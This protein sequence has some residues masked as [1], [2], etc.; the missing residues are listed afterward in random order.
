MYQEGV[1]QVTEMNGIESLRLILEREQ[2]RPFAFEEASD[3]AESM[4]SFYEVLAAHAE[5]KTLVPLAS[6]TQ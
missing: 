4:L 5:D 1:E 3:V 2:G 6:N